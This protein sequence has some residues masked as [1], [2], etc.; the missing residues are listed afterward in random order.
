MPQKRGEAVYYGVS[1]SFYELLLNGIMVG[2]DFFLVCTFSVHSFAKVCKKDLRLR[3]KVS[4][5]A[6]AW[7]WI[8]E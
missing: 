3:Q 1:S 7:S 6:D 2:L 5:E 4:T 8:P